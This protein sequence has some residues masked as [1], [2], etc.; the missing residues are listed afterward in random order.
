VP[1]RRR[2]GLSVPT[3]PNSRGGKGKGYWL[4][5]HLD[6]GG[7]GIAEISYRTG[8]KGGKEKKAFG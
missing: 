8:K 1:S 2:V 4:T 6:N 5:S 3:G 7:K